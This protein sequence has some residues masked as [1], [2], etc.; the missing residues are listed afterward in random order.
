MG[1]LTKEVEVVLNSQNISYYESLGYEIPRYYN[2]QF[3]KMFHVKQKRLDFP[4]IENQ[5]FFLCL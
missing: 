5:V 1:L 2:R 3:K 4:I